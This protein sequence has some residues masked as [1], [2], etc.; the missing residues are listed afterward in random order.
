[1]S[2]EPLHL[3]QTGDGGHLL[4]VPTETDKET[5]ATITQ[6]LSGS[7]EG[8]RPD[9]NRGPGPVQRVTDQFGSIPAGLI[10]K[11]I[12]S[13]GEATDAIRTRRDELYRN[14]FPRIEPRYA[15]KCDDCGAE[16]DSE[17][18]EC[19]ACG[20]QN[21]HPPDP[22][23]KRRAKRLFESINPQGQSLRDVA[24]RAEA[25]QWTTGVS[26]LV[27]QHEYHQAGDSV[28]YR[29]GEIY[30][31]EPTAI[32]RADPLALVPVVDEHGQPGGHWYVCPLH[33]DDHTDSP[34]RCPRCDAELREVHFVEEPNKRTDRRY[35]LR[36]EVLTWA[37]PHPRLHGLDGLAPSVHVW[38]KQAILQMM[39][40]Y[41]GSFY[42][43]E[44]DRMPNQFM[45]LHTSNP[46]QWESELQKAR[47]DG[48]QYDSPIFTNQYSP[49]DST[50]PE[51][52]VVDAMPDELLGQNSEM[53]KQFKSD[54]R[55]AYGISDVH[56]S[57]LEDAG[58]LNNEGLQLEVTDRSLASQMHDYREG[59]LDTLMKRLGFEG[60]RISFLPDREIDPQE[61]SK[62]LRAASFVHQAGGQAEIVDGRIQVD[63]FEVN[64]DESDDPPT[65]SGQPN[66]P[67]VGSPI[68]D[69]G[70]PDENPVGGL[71][72]TRTPADAEQL[73]DTVSRLEAMT[74]GL[75]FGE[76]VSQKGAPVYQ[77]R[78]DVPQNVQN[79]INQA[80]REHDFST[81]DA[82]SQR[83]LEDVIEPSL[84]Q[85]QG[86][87]IDSIV[88]RLYREGDVERDKARVVARDHVSQILN[89]ARE[90]AVATLAENVEEQVLHYWDGPDDENVT[91]MCEW[92][93]GETNPEYG[94]DPVPM[95]E[96]KR[97]Q[98]EAVDR[99]SDADPDS[100]YVT[101]HHLH[102]QER[103]TH[104][105]ILANEVNT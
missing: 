56:D 2:T 6:Q 100:K 29:E 69:E 76:P 86:W 42:D 44:A 54:I 19:S 1:M 27:I 73:A 64:I 18:A 53:K 97:L 7:S 3:G 17:Q 26:T 58:G 105:S 99:F 20:S 95:Q 22:D 98:R 41:A 57:E 90:D 67:G 94:G 96:L 103:H 40:R 45:I 62:H 74:T 30:R 102:P 49:Q 21:L 50:Q 13:G 25:D 23:E 78:A 61:L 9:G 38:L 77:R 63:D 89:K 83:A 52:Q 88:N 37:Y 71:A 10:R 80:V 92:L 75:L 60:W 36:N 51:I 12:M 72:E 101:D 66:L 81:S 32:Y 14:E 48:D 5:V 35:Y 55:Q 28:L 87:S 59:W 43:P 15:E 65:L 47:D 79:R 70:T 8:P 85:P 82:V 33:R 84:T 16:F 104:R 34:G 46:D 93:K 31:E 39:D 68:P 4:A 91:E 11:L 24:K